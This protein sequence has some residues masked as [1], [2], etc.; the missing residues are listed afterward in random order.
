MK[1][2]FG[3]KDVRLIRTEVR[4]ETVSWVVYSR[5]LLFCQPSERLYGPQRTVV[6]GYFV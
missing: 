3:F 6:P 2:I 4:D 1:K 5:L